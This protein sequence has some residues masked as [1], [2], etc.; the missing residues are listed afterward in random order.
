LVPRTGILFGLAG[1]VIPDKVI[2][3]SAQRG[4]FT[5][6]VLVYDLA[7]VISLVV[8]VAPLDLTVAERVPEGFVLGSGPGKH[9]EEPALVLMD[10]GHVLGAGQL[11]IRDVE[12]IAPSGQ[13][14]EEIP[15][16]A[17]GL[18]VH[19]I[20]AGNLEIQRNCA[21]PGHREDIE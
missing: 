2:P 21:V 10:I 4:R 16:S 15:G 13:A 11:A 12:E 14:T 5:D 6:G 18:V 20:A 1:A 8:D 19:H 9:G 3:L 7:L 17:M